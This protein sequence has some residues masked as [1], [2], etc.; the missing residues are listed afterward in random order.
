[1]E[2]VEMAGVEYNPLAAGWRLSGDLDVNY[3]VFATKDG[4]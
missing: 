1:M 2:I 4:A 3:M